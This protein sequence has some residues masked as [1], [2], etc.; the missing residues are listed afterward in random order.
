MTF[1]TRSAALCLMTLAVA[2]AGC[3]QGNGDGYLEEGRAVADDGLSVS[4]T[5]DEVV[6]SPGDTVN[7]TVYVTNTSSEPVKYNARNAAPVYVMV[8]KAS[9]L[10]EGSWETVKKYPEAAAQVITPME[11][12]PGQQREF[13]M[14]LPVEPDWPTGETV[15]LAAYPN[16]RRELVASVRIKVTS[17]E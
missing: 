12:R 6:V 2:I 1:A 15:R 3:P 7:V 4:I 13:K 10:A 16:G 9:D 5:A 11:F 8:Q 14:S 17:S